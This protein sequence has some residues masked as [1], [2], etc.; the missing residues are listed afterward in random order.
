[1]S[2]ICR[3]SIGLEVPSKHY[4]RPSPFCLLYLSLRNPP[5]H[6][7]LEISSEQSEP[8]SAPARPR[9]PSAPQ[10]AV[11]HGSAHDSERQNGGCIAGGPVATHEVGRGSGRER[12]QQQHTCQVLVKW[13]SER[14]E[15]P[16]PSSRGST[17]TAAEFGGGPRAAASARAAS[18]LLCGCG[19]APQSSHNA[20]PG[21]AP[22]QVAAARAGRVG[23]TPCAARCVCTRRWRV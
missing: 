4:C 13:Q 6:G 18:S 15:N 3:F 2:D 12:Q 11:R 16:G 7:R 1:M 8:A 14:F 9:A 21:D 22:E 20:Q 10:P 23:C 5:F 19:A 17:S